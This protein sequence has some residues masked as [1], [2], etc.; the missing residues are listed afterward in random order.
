MH[1]CLAVMLFRADHCQ[2]HLYRVTDSK[3]QIWCQANHDDAEEL[4]SR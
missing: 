3:Y 2:Q 4:L 1:C